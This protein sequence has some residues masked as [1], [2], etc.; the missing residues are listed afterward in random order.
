MVTNIW[1]ASCGAAYTA[2]MTMQK[3]A[4]VSKS[5]GVKAEAPKAVT[6]TGRADETRRERWTFLTNHA[7]VLLHVSN[8]PDDT[9]S[10]IADALSL[11]ERTTAYVLADLRAAGYIDVRRSGRHNHY[12]VRTSKPLRRRAHRRAHV[13]DLLEALAKLER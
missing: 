10:T 2:N 12:V 13:S 11:T 3:H 8:H 5:A 1:T 4:G 7:A 6:R 9:V